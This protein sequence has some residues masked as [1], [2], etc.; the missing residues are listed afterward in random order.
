MGMFTFFPFLFVIF[1]LAI[2]GGIF[3]LIY[4]WAKYM[5]KI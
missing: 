4:T 2:L 1:Y 5:T 3:Y